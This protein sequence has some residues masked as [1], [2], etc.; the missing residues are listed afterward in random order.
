M[1]RST[2]IMMLVHVIGGNV[3]CSASDSVYCHTFLRNV[4]CLLSSC[5]PRREGGVGGLAT[6]GL[7]MFGGPTVGQKYKVRQNVPF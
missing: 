7:A 1:L 4:V 2:K 3:S 6:P 5:R